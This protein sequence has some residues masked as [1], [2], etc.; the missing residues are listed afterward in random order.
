MG[1]NGYLNSSGA[2]TNRAACMVLTQISSNV[3]DSG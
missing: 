2:V 3:D 1:L